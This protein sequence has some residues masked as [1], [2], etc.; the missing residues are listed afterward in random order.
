MLLSHQAAGPRGALEAL[1]ITLQEIDG[2]AD[3]DP[4]DPALTELKSAIIR[5]MEELESTKAPRLM[6]A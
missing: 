1:Q 6:R 2:R 5:T 4:L 3:I